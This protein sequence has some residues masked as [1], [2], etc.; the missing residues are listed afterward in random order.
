M[1]T[2]EQLKQDVTA[3]LAWDPATHATQIGVA[4]KDGVVTLSGHIETF[5]QKHAAVRAAQRVA[6]IRAL[7]VELDVR[8]LHEHLR[9]DTEIATN[10]EL[11][12]SWNTAVSP[13]AVQLT[14]ERGWVTLHGEV[15]W[16]FQR[17]SVEKA[18]RP[19]A[20]VVG[21]SNLITLRAQPRVE[22]LQRKIEEALIRQTL[23]EINRIHVSVDGHT[24]RLSGKVDSWHEREAAQ[25]VA[26]SA[27]GVRAVINDLIVG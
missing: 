7:A 25:G 26:W 6:G 21:I 3:E 15:D 11:A 4:V 19:L 16:D 17:R 2:D 20:G 12:L 22:D 10:A 13:N 18:V 23:R 9:N 27:P 1:K 24:V 14:V 5:A 8:L